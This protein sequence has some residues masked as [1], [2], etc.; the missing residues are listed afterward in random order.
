VGRLDRVLADVVL[1][2]EDVLPDLLG[3]GRRLRGD[4]AGGVEQALLDP[5]AQAEACG[6]RR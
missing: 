5:L 1:V 2:R 4:H 6:Y 3:L